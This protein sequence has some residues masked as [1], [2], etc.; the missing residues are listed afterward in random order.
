MSPAGSGPPPPG[1]RGAG[2]LP[3]GWPGE[4][5]PGRRVPGPPPLS[6]SPADWLG[7]HLFARRVVMLSGNIDGATGDVI[8]QLLT[9]D[10]DGDEAIE[11]YVDGGGED[12]GAA[13]AL[14]DVIDML[15]VEVHTTVMGR[16]DGTAVGVVAVCPVRRV[17]PN[18][19]LALRQPRF[20][21]SAS[22]RDLAAW[23]D[24]TRRQL[25][26]YVSRLADACH[27]SPDTVRDD[28]E[29]GL[30]LDA[31]GAVAYGLA[32]SVATQLR[33]VAGNSES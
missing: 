14:M 23:S 2:Q 19:R 18:A 22:A 32:D 10:A 24:Y 28:M 33:V 1:R 26:S 16:A 15:G 31:A 21:F 25:D 27:T 4:L 6:A 17:S 11:L 9:M 13:L 29:R 7:G 30:I 20:Q 5:P 12:V 3:P 8:A